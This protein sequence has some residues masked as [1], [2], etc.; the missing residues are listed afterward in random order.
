MLTIHIITLFPEALAP[1]LEASILGRAV[2]ARLL[3]FRLWNLKDFTEKTK[4]GKLTRRVD[5][6]AYGGGPGMVLRPEPVLRALDKIFKS[7]K[8]KVKP[9]VVVFS[10]S[11]P[12]FEQA[13]ASRWARQKRDLI[14]I[15]GRYEGLDARVK[16]ILRAELLSIGPYVLAGGELPALVVAEAVARH[17]PGVLGD[18]ESLEEKRI[19]SPEVYTRPEILEYQGKRYRVPK[20]LLSGHHQEI[21]KWRLDKKRKI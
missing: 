18:P 2:R 6:R 3:C 20:V 19:A 17:L 1:Y 10:P 4:G 9:R 15:A 21:D 11:G 13:A 16:K 14:L 5:D 12:M 7:Y 8:T